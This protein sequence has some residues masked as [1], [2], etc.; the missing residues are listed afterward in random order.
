MIHLSNFLDTLIGHISNDNLFFLI[1]SMLLTI[2][3]MWLCVLFYH[4]CLRLNVQA[5]C[6]HI[7]SCFYF[8]ARHHERHH[9]YCCLFLPEKN[10]R[11]LFRS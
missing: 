7:F 1:V 6:F 8:L 10:Y 5:F 2:I 3:W 4:H 11:C 9:V